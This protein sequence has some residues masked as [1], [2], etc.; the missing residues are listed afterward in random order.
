[1]SLV[2]KV[3]GQKLREEQ[4]YLEQLVSNPFTSDHQI[5]AQRARV[6][7]FLW[8]AMKAYEIEEKK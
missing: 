6:D 3:I 5:I 1:M 7:A 8:A 2:G 4:K